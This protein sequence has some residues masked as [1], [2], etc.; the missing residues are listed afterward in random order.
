[1][2]LKGIF[3]DTTKSM[4]YKTPDSQ[5]SF[6]YKGVTEQLEDLDPIEEF[7]SQ[8]KG[9]TNTIYLARTYLSMQARVC[10]DIPEPFKV[11]NPGY[12][13]FHFD[14]IPRKFQTVIKA[15]NV[16]I[17][18]HH[19]LAH[20]KDLGYKMRRDPGQTYI[21]TRGS[22]GARIYLK[23][24][25]VD[26]PAYKTKAVDAS[27]AGDAFNAGFIAAHRRG[28][29]IIDSVKYGNATSSF[30]VEKWGCQTNLPSWEQ[31]EAR[32]ERIK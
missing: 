19:E 16:I 28:F 14:K 18:N 7:G 10:K 13:V 17:L 11:Y 2:F 32:V 1:M 6:F 27:G 21:I 29:D 22:E 3:G 4:F 5:I 25:Q 23:D 15:S 31:V 26:I 9:H 8:I 30:I 12:G 20:L 24:V